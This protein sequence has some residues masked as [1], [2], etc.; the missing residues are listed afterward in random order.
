MLNIQFTPFPELA[1]ERLVLRRMRPADAPQ[2]FVLRSDPEMMQFIPRPLHQT[3]AD[4]LALID[5]CNDT[6]DKNDGISWAVTEKGKD[7]LIGTIGFVKI[8]KEHFRAEVGYILHPAMQGKGIMKEALATVIDYG[9]REMKLH[10]IAAIVD[11]ANTASAMLLEK[12]GFMKEGHLREH[13]FLLGR[14]WD[15]V[16]YSKLKYSF[17]L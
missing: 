1:T 14:F 7:V 10:S 11:P 16:I 13:E 8:Q 6:A 9:F 17:E 12:S 15:S 2:L 3:E 5:L 4:S